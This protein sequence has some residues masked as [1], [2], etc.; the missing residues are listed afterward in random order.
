[1]W[2][3]VQEDAQFENSQMTGCQIDC[4]ECEMNCW[5]THIF[6]I[7]KLQNGKLIAMNVEKDAGHRTFLKLKNDRLAS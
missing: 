6:K 7:R 1:M 2:K 4:N 5:T 3:Q